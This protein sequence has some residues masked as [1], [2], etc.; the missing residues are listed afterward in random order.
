MF[1]L[2]NDI[3]QITYRL[4]RITHHIFTFISFGNVVTSRFFNSVVFPSQCAFPV[5]YYKMIMVRINA[6]VEIIT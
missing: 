1:H 6:N 2:P 3:V 5:Y 4:E